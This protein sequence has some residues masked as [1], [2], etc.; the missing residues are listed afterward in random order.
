LRSFKEVPGR[1]R[2]KPGRGW[3]VGWSKRLRLSALQRF[4][5][6]KLKIS[7]TPDRI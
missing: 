3:V 7:W 4:D 2:L 1:V 5:F 6:M